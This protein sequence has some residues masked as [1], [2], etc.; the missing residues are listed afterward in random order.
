MHAD[1]LCR[2]R[3]GLRDHSPQQHGQATALTDYGNANAGALKLFGFGAKVR[4]KQ[5][6]QRT[7]FGRRAFPVV[8]GE[9]IHRELFDTQA[10][11]VFNDVVHRA[12]AGQVSFGTGHT[13]AFGPSSVAVHDDREMGWQERSSLFHKAEPEK[14]GA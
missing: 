13:S 6:E 14:E 10:G 12:R 2:A 4:R 5:F 8:A 11:T 7:D 3:F 9:G 1:A